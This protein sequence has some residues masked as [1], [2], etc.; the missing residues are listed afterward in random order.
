MKT[1]ADTRD[2]TPPDTGQDKSFVSLAQ[3]LSRILVGRYWVRTQRSDSKVE[4]ICEVR[5]IFVSILAGI[6]IR[7]DYQPVKS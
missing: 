2:I 5:S 3:D 6:T 7:Y 4:N 1:L